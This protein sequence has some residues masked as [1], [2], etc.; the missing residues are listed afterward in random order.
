L[1]NLKQRLV[2]GFG[3]FALMM[4]GILGNEWTFGVVFLIISTV[5][6]VE[7]YTILH[8][9]AYQTL[10]WQGI[11][12]HIIGYI[13]TFGVV[14]QYFSPQYYAVLAVLSIG[15]NIQK[16]YDRDD[17][18]PF[19]AMALTWAGLLYV[20][21]P[22]WAL[23]WAVFCKGYYSYQVI[24]GLFF[25]IWI[26]DVVA[27][28]IGSQFGKTPLFARI[29]PKKSWEGTFG[30]SLSVFIL[31]YI[32]TH[33]LQDLSTFAWFGVASIVVIFA[34]YGDLAESMFKRSLHIKDAS[35]Y[36]PGHGGFLDRFDGI[37][38]I[39]PLVAIFLQL[40]VN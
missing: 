21:V 16:L 11:F 14:M 38:L 36:L 15:M 1:D 27:Y 24:L 37:L 31:A 10:F 25:L 22:F 3:G 7:F 8:Q 29:S 6:L 26:H 12:A 9:H 5:C 35:E 4:T 32:I 2:Y 39:S 19:L 40:L 33:Y 17:E 34:N 20:A 23:Q 18:R 30:G 28:F 13:I